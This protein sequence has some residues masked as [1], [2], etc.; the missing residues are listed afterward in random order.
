MIYNILQRYSDNGDD[1]LGLMF[2]G[3]E[4]NLSLAGHTLEDE[5][6]LIK[7]KG[8]TRIKAGKYKL[9]LRKV[10]SP[11]TLKYRARFSWFT[12]HIQIMEVSRF[13]YVYVHIGNDDDDTDACVLIGD[14]A[15]NNMIAPGFISNSALAYERWYMRHQGHLEAGG[16]AFI[17]IRDEDWIVRLQSRG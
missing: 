16:E 4:Y 5:K 10:D 11:L 9:K 2:S 13:N 15:N 12:W 3:E 6:R 8:E 7:V 1:T 17:E 14:G